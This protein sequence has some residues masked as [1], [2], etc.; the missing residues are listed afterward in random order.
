M[1]AKDA[2]T[3]DADAYRIEPLTALCLLSLDPDRKAALDRLRA[4]GLKDGT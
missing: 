4:G 3:T 2:S 1:A